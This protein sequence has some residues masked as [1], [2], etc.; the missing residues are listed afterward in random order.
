MDVYWGETVTFD[1]TTHNPK[2]GQVQDDDA[3]PLAR[4]FQDGID[5]PILSPVVTKRVA[6]TGDYRITFTV[7]TAS[8][9]VIEHAYN[10]VV[11]ATVTGIQ[12]KARIA[13]FVPRA[14]TAAVHFRV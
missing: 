4:V 2:T 7:D 5:V 14:R 3:L 8:G 12:A 11:I 9:F 13:V 10:L 1:F 6:L